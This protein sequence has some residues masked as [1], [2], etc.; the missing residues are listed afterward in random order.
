MPF[1]QVLLVAMLLAGHFILALTATL[2]KCTTYDEIAHLTAGYSIWKYNDY[3][4]DGAWAQRWAALP[5]IWSKPRPVFPE[6]LPEKRFWQASNVWA[7]G[8]LFFYH[9]DNDA[10]AMLLKGRTMIALLGV[11]LG[12]LIF[13]YARRLFGT[14]AG[15]LS[16]MLF[17]ICPTLLANGALITADLMASSFFLAS[18]PALWWV[19]HEVTPWSL[20]VCGFVLGGLFLS[21][22]SAVIIVPVAGLLVLVRLANGQSLPVRWWVQ[23]TV[24]GRLHLLAAFAAVVAVET[25]II[26]VMIWVS[27]GCRYSAMN[28]PTPSDQLRPG[29]I[30][31]LGVADFPQTTGAL[32]VWTR[33]HRLL[34]EA[35]LYWFAYTLATSTGRES[36]LNGEYS[37]KGFPPRFFPYTFLVKTPLGT[38]AVLLLAG[39]SVQALWNWNR[40]VWRDTIRG[41]Y[42]TAPLWIFLIVYWVTAATSHINIGHRHI[43]PTYP[44]MIV[45]AGAAARF[46]PG[47]LNR[48]DAKPA[49][50][51]Q[52]SI[53]CGLLLATALGWATVESLRTWP[54]Y[55]TYFNQIAGGPEDGYRHLVDSSLDWGQ[56]LPDLKKWLEK[57]DPDRKEKVYLDYFGNGPFFPPVRPILHAQP[58][59]TAFAGRYA[60]AASALGQFSS[61]YSLGPLEAALIAGGTRIGGE[62][63]ELPER[64]SDTLSPGIYCISAT[65]LQG[66]YVGKFRGPW[67]DSY[68]KLYRRNLEFLELYNHRD[69]PASRKLLDYLEERDAL[70]GKEDKWRANFAATYNELRFA[71]LRKYLRERR[72]PD[73]QINHSIMIY[74]VTAED[75]REAFQPMVL[76]E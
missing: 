5:L 61:P 30:E 47:M 50:P 2:R 4:F 29:W 20:V 18:L 40:R 60:R 46:W 71:R 44:A 66:I 24:T 10:D 15:F 17:A 52:A 14:L 1:W 32:I 73:A 65:H 3:R 21:K 25:V 37:D 48:Q 58:P 74:R 22:Y 43:L 11:V 54:N 8:K 16:L 36:F 63:L 64:I 7:T 38:L 13:W 27:F 45:L 53:F 34:P 6:K 41:F 75:L 69:E 31:V 51:I 72:E 55:L 59:P 42:A 39:L 57:H 62:Y 26:W 49:Y 19:L 68:E 33:D 76:A 67:K 70:A 9:K 28:K 12:G 56:D 23:K 35:Y